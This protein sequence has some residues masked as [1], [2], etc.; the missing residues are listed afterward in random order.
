MI[1][2]TTIDR[3]W[4]GALFAGAFLAAS[5]PGAALMAQ[6]L[7]AEG[8]IETI[9]GSEVQEEEAEAAADP[10]TVIAAIENTPAAISAVRMTTNLDTVDIVFLSD[11]TLAEGGPPA[12]IEATIQEHLAE[13]TELRRELEGNAMLF[14][15]INSRSVLMRD[16]LAVEFNDENGVVIYAAAQPP[17]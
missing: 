13:I 7:D 12:E 15:A 16:V 14:H 11:A 3:K 5:A 2:A 6:G 1:P 4:L 9:I 8:A 10:A 17:A